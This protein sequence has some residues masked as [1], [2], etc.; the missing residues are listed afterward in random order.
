[1]YSTVQQ[2]LSRH[3]ND[4]VRTKSFKICAVV[5]FISIFMEK[6]IHKQN[7]QTPIPINHQPDA[8]IFQFIVLTFIYSSTC[9]GRSPVHH[10]KLNDCSSSLWFYL[11]I[12]VI[13]VLCL[14]S[15]RLY[16]RPDHKHGTGITTI[17]I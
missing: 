15:G 3:F 10:Q 17:R 6:L 11:R 8:K 2:Q 7:S 9:F 16:N 4:G 5:T 13:A 12:V 1:M 14:W